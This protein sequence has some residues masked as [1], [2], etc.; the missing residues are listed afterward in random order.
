MAGIDAPTQELMTD[1][2]EEERQKGRIILLA[3]HD[4]A[5]ASRACDC[6]CCLNERLVAFGP[7]QQTYTTENLVETFGGPVI[8]LG[9]STLPAAASAHS[10]VKEANVIASRLVQ[11]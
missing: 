3:T 4:L 8:M 6:L 9:A 2:I 11:P 5:S 10:H 7:L 1:V